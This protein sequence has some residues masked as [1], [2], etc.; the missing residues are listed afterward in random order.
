MPPVGFEPTIAAG[1]RSK[2]YTLDRAATGTGIQSRLRIQKRDT[3]YGRPQGNKI[4]KTA[5]T[6]GQKRGMV[7]GDAVG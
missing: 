6:V 2:T 1:E 3:P 7:R 5:K 4:K